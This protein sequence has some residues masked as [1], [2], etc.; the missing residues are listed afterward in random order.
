MVHSSLI[1]IS[2]LAVVADHSNSGMLLLLKRMN[3]LL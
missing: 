1:T 3:L 2:K